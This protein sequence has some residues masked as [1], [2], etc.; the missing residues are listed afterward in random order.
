MTAG[1]I[2]RNGDDPRST[3]FYCHDGAWMVRLLDLT[4]RRLSFVGKTLSKPL[5][6]RN[7]LDTNLS[8]PI[9]FSGAQH[10]ARHVVTGSMEPRR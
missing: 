7:E 5:T 8:A 4:A 10:T 1:T 6:L 9:T 3:G 2:I